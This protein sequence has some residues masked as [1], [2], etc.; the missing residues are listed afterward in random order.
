MFLREP[1]VE[2]TAF[3]AGVFG[4]P[5]NDGVWALL[6]HAGLQGP[7]IAATKMLLIPEGAR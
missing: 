1:V 5:S 2:T 6:A 3:F 4:R 7:E